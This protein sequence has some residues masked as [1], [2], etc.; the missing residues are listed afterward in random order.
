VPDVSVAGILDFVKSKKV[1]S[2]V[3]MIRG[4]GFLGDSKDE[5]PVAEL[6]GGSRDLGDS[7]ECWNSGASRF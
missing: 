3:R 7:W 2:A 5:F 1:A 6:A 4:Q